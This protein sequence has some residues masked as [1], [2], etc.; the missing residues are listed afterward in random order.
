MKKLILIVV[1]VVCTGVSQA[2]STSHKINGSVFSANGVP[3]IGASLFFK[4]NRTSAVSDAKGRFAI[5]LSSFPDTLII[6]HLGYQRKQIPFQKVPS[7]ALVVTLETANTEL[8]GVTVSTGYQQT[9]K[10]RATGSFDFIDN[11]LLNRS[12]STDVLSRLKGTANGLLFNGQPYTGIVTSP[13]GSILGINIRG[14][15]TLSSKVNTDPLI[16]VDN[17]PYEGDIRNINPNDIESITI[18]KDA[19]A[20]SIWGAR[21]GNGVI[22]ITTK[23]GR[24]NEK[25]RVRANIN[26]TIGNK[27]DVFYD[28]NFL[29]SSDFIDIEEL[30]FSKGYF[31]ADI[32]NKSNMPLLSPIVQILAEQRAGKL[33]ESQAT[34]QIDALRKVD[35][36]ND[37]MKYVYQKSVKQQYS[38]G[39]SGGSRKMAYQFS[40]GYDNNRDNLIRNGYNRITINSQNTYKPV[41]NLEITGAI[42]YSQSTTTQNNQQG[43]GNISSGG[44]YQSLYPYAKLADQKGNPSPIAKDYSNT[45]I[46]SVQNIGFLNWQYSPLNEIKNSDNNTKIS[47]LLL[48]ISGKYSFTDYMGINIQYQHERQQVNSTDYNNLKTYYTRNLINEFSIYDPTTN[49]FSY[50]VPM[51]GILDLGT[52]NWEVNNLRGQVYFNKTFNPYNSL[53]AIAGAEIRQ[54]KT[55]GYDRTSYGY[56]DQFG[57]AIENLNYADYL[58]A[59]PSGYKQI[60]NPDGNVTGTLN[61]Y[62]SYYANAAYTYKNR[63]TLSISGRK[64]GANIFGAK[65]NEKITPLWST[66]LLWTISNEDF[67]NLKWLP[68]LKLRAT[69]G[70][71]GNV[72]SGS[73]YPTG[74]YLTGSLTGQP[75]IINIS[76]PNPELRWEKVRNVNIGV[77]FTVWKSILTGSLEFYR[78]DGR[79]L[80]ENIPLAPSTGYLTYAGN[81]AKTQTHGIELNLQSKVINRS[82]QWNIA[83]ILNTLHDKVVQYNAKMNSSTIQNNGSITGITGKPLYALFSYKWG[84]LD[85]QNGNP[86]GYLNGKISEDY[87]AIINNYDPDSLTYNGSARP[88]LFGSLINTFSYKGFALSIMLMYKL[89]YYFRRSS[90]GLNYT[91]DISKYMNE[92]YKKRWQKPGDERSTNVPSIIYPSNSN[93]GRF[94]RYSSILVSSADHIRLQDIR[95]S[96]NLSCL[97]SH[98]T[99]LAHSELYLY[100]ENLGII[101]RANK[102]GIDPDNYGWWG[103]HTL[104]TPFSMAAGLNIKF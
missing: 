30:L 59:N 8:Q 101:W 23:K 1:G 6:S 84:G 46:D 18:L 66:G 16:V 13:I 57:T 31:D 28:R 2:Q 65:T 42:N 53:N 94:Y 44:K 96:Y 10:E 62:I 71:N 7:N 32:A 79:D 17:F 82:F 95:L 29:N 24:L 89:G 19:A 14:R 81:A 67:Y 39:I 87:S 63:Y 52:Y 54:L 55:T 69:Y 61:R 90:I 45:Y 22:V 20:A 73:A 74:G 91:D 58:A 92:D 3:L 36:R 100:A 41:R 64:D 70:F 25:M 21:A 102:F 12:V 43:Y 83:L 75:L 27:P 37:F 80:I 88:T 34:A 5:S 38:A 33:P 76:A 26:V 93:R 98:S 48:R 11:K 72:Y 40:V 50:Q 99:F 77:D 97:Q 4:K 78:K 103:T 85:P 56:D 86:Q 47:D 49:S 104:P 15:S 35:V 51:G 60:P 68:F 9:P